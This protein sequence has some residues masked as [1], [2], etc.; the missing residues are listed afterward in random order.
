VF[1]KGWSECLNVKSVV[2][3]EFVK[4]EQGEPKAAFGFNNFVQAK[5]L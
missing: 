5:E 2:E 1:P 3:I 4:K